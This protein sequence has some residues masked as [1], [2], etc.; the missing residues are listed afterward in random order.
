MSVTKIQ[1]F[2]EA[3]DKSGIARILSQ[4]DTVE[5]VVD[6]SGATNPRVD[7]PRSGRSGIS[8]PHLDAVDRIMGD[9]GTCVF[10]ACLDIVHFEIGIIRQHVV[11]ALTLR[12]K[13]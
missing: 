7:G 4:I 10:E 1:F 6:L 5:G 11:R 3:A 13:A 9:H 2:A 8:R 12:E